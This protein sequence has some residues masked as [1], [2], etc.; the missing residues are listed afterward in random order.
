[1][2]RTLSGLFLVGALNRPRKRKRTNRE[3]PRRVPEQIREKSRKNRESPKKDKKGQKRTKKEGQV[4]I[5][6][7]PPFET[8]PFSGPWNP[9]DSL[10]LSLSP[11]PSNRKV[12]RP[13]RSTFNLWR[14]AWAT[15]PEISEKN[16]VAQKYLKV[17]F[18]GILK[19]GQKVSPEEGF[20]FE[21]KSK[22]YFW[23]YFLTYFESSP[24]TYFWATFGLLYFFGDF[25]SCGS[26]GP[27]QLLTWPL[28]FLVPGGAPRT[29]FIPLKGAPGTL[30]SLPLPENP[31]KV[32]ATKDHSI[33]NPPLRTPGVPSSDLIKSVLCLDLFCTFFDRHPRTNLSGEKNS[34]HTPQCHVCE[35][36][37]SPRIFLR[38]KSSMDP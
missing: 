30:F 31:S 12:Q 3:N 35:P 10:S 33:S 4:Q 2:S 37:I 19:V 13:L 29:L 17:D 25:L 32:V 8:P 5:G 16:K 24:G 23:T 18:K 26:R 21:V 1:M 20:P 28:W 22:S 14:P 34:P 27:S 6:K 36:K 9:W 15:R 38:V 7:P 11:S